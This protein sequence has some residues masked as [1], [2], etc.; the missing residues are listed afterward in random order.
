[1]NNPVSW[2]GIPIAHLADTPWPVRARLLAFLADDCADAAA[3]HRAILAARLLASIHPD[4][5]DVIAARLR[6]NGWQ[7]DDA[8]IRRAKH[9]DR[10]RLTRATS[11]LQRLKDRD[12]MRRLRQRRRAA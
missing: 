4:T 6:D 9:R 10:M 7:T 5:P 12:A 8:E 2:R 1:M 3:R 11:P